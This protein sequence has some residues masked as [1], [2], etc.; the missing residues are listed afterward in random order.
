VLIRKS[1]G[2]AAA[3][4]HRVGDH[5]DA[6]RHRSCSGILRWRYF[7]RAASQ[8]LH[9]LPAPSSTA[10]SSNCAG[11]NCAALLRSSGAS[12]ELL[13]SLAERGTARGGF[14]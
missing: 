5:A 3:H 14:A 1:G 8:I 12:T 6:G 13:G 11:S 2:V 10:R 9:F 7:F 4:R